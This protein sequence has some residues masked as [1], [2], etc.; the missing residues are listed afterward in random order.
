MFDHLI[1]LHPGFFEINLPTE[2]Q[3]RVT[4]DTTLL[5]TVIGSSVSVALRNV[6]MLVGG[7]VLLVA[8]NLKLSLIVLASAPE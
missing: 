7:I 6:L 1:N 4:T 5:Q 2:I 8:S 3:S